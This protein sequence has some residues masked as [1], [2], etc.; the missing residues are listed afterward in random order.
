MNENRSSRWLIW[1][2]PLFALL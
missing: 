1:T 2:G